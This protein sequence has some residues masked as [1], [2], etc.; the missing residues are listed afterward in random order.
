MPQMVFPFVLLYGSDELAALE[1]A[2]TVLMWWGHS[3]H[4]TFPHPPVHITGKNYHWSSNIEASAQ[5]IPKIELDVNH[6]IIP[7]GLISLAFCLDLNLDRIR[8]TVVFISLVNIIMYG[9]QHCATH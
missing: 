9:R 8:P 2:M 1:T 4:A 6:W 7:M 3:F 5:G